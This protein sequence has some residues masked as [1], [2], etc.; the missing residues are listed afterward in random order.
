MMVVNC[1]A[2]PEQLVES[3]LFGHMKGAFT[4]AIQDQKGVFEAA[5]GSTVFLDEIGELSPAAQAALLRVLDTNRVMRVGSTR[6]IDVDVRVLAATHRTLEAMFERGAFREDLFYRLSAMTLTVPSL[7]ERPD[8]V[9][10]LVAR[11]LR[12][13]GHAYGGRVRGV[14][15][16]AL[17]LLKRYPWPGNVRELRNAIHRAVAIA[18][19]D[20]IG[21]EDLPERVCRAAG[22]SPTRQASSGGAGAGK[23]ALQPDGLKGTLR[24]LEIQLILDALDAAKGNQTEAAKMLKVPLRTL[25][26]RIKTL[27]IRKRGFGVS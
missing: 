8:D 18:Q 23:L 1:G 21:E 13:A 25:A 16:S 22:A 3:T 5:D 14:Q 11:F 4:G 2:I 12:E 6:E 19:S 27:G 24:A 9:E 17:A 7:R 20:E 15:P 10:P 26:H